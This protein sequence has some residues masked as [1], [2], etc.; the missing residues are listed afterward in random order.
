MYDLLAACGYENNIKL[1]DELVI[2]KVP[3]KSIIF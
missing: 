3:E 1:E 2:K